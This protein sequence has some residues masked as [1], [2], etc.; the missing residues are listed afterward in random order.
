MLL[1]CCYLS[2]HSH[3]HDLLEAAKEEPVLVYEGLH[4]VLQV[5][6]HRLELVKVPE[7][8]LEQGRPPADRQVLAVHAV[9]LAALGHSAKEDKLKNI[10]FSNLLLLPDEVLDEELEHSVL[11]C[12]SA[13][14]Q[15]DPLIRLFFLIEGCWQLQPP[16]CG[17]QWSLTNNL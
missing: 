8:V 11:L 10:S 14:L 16:T 12:Y 5:R 7:L 15:S 1:G 4:H 13:V 17:H 3:H 2:L 6:P 9:H